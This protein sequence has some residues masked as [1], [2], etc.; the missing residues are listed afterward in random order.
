MI[1]PKFLGGKVG[2]RQGIFFMYNIFMDQNFPDHRLFHSFCLNPHLSFET[3]E[4]NEK[5][6]L[7]LRGHPVT[8]IS[9]I[10]TS[11]IMIILPVFFYSLIVNYLKMNQV[12][13]I[14]IFWYFLSFSFIFLNLLSYIFNVGI[15][16]NRRVVDIDFHNILFKEFSATTIDKIEDVT[17]RT[18]GFLANFLNFGNLLIQTAGEEQN[19]EFLNIP[20]PTEA[21]TIINQLMKKNLHGGTH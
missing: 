18:G 8:Q 14:L 15:I 17:V 2:R 10:V 4:N 16:T 20:Y 1:L 21:A 5:V 3:Q 11:I 12:L 13:F 7:V 6:I 19:I 9:W